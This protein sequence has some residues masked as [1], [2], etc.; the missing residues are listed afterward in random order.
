MSLNEALRSSVCVHSHN[1]RAK[2]LSGLHTT[3]W[4]D[5]SHKNNKAIIRDSNGYMVCG[6]A[7]VEL[8]GLADWVPVKER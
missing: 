4:A 8:A 1:Q 3:H 5:W 2:R 6:K 7:A